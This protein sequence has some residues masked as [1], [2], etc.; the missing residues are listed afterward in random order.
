MFSRIGNLRHMKEQMNK[1]SEN[2]TTTSG[3]LMKKSIEAAIN[4]G[5]QSVFVA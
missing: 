1:G 4:M 2:T 5:K 3:Y